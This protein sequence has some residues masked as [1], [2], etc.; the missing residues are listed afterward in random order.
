[1]LLQEI[2]EVQ[3]QAIVHKDNLGAILLAKNRQVGIRTNR[4]DLNHHFIR[5][6]VKEKDM[7]IKCI[8]IR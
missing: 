4:V 1:M 7:D 3:K 5:D 6:T 8:R 2:S